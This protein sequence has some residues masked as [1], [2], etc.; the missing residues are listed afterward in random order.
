[1]KSE[2]RNSK[3]QKG[4]TLIEVLV[5]MLFL[6]CIFVLYSAALNT[7]LLSKKLK[8][9][10][11]AYHIA[12]KQMEDLRSTAL[13]SLPS[14]GVISDPQLSDIP[15]GAGSF[16]VANY[17]SFSG[18]KEIVVTVTWNDG[19]SRQVVIRSLAGSGGINP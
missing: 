11:T 9:E 17:A 1:M 12:N 15:S 4:F 19:S 6:G 13:A 8:N 16:T 10:N 7:V 18:M 2:I 3:S 5:S 14:S